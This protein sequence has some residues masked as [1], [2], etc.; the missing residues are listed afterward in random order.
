M[1]NTITFNKTSNV[2]LNSGIIGLYIY[3]NKYKEENNLIISL[4]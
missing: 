1:I 3:L 4:S 2:F